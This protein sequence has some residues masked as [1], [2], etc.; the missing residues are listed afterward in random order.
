MQSLCPSAVRVENSHTKIIVFL[1]SRGEKQSRTDVDVRMSGYFPML[2]SE[3]NFPP[4]STGE[5]RPATEEG[6]P[7]PATR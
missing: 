7:D 4:L 6:Q 5:T 1:G 2:P 3:A